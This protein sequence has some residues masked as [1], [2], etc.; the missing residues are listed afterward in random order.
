MPNDYWPERFRVVLLEF[1]T[2]D[3]ALAWD[4]AGQPIEL[5]GHAASKEVQPQ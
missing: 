1:D 2:P 4:E 3:A 5:A